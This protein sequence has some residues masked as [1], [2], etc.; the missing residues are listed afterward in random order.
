VF[1]H[2]VG[3]AKLDSRII[4]YDFRERLR[5]SSCARVSMRETRDATRTWLGLQG[6]IYLTARRNHLSSTQH[7]IP[8]AGGAKGRIKEDGGTHVARR[9][10]E[11]T[12]P[13]LAGRARIFACLARC[14][15]PV[16]WKIAQ[17]EVVDSGNSS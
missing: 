5:I 8:I 9:R 3:L 10:K 4:S 13:S 12:H 2:W 15:P 17:F 1:V 7:I 6:W 14:P 16:A 11:I